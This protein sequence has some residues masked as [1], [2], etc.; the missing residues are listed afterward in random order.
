[1]K[2]EKQRRKSQI[3]KCSEANEASKRIIG[4][5]YDKPVGA[6]S[7][8]MRQKHVAT[9]DQ[10]KL[11]KSKHK[12]KKSGTRFTSEQGKER[13]QVMHSLLY[14]AAATT[15]KNGAETTTSASSKPKILTLNNKESSSRTFAE[16]QTLGTSSCQANS[17]SQ[18]DGLVITPQLP[19]SHRSTTKVNEP[20]G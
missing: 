18:F 9:T 6:K 5:P 11:D 14:Q 16:N 3:S 7:K 17:T 10:L 13:H 20:T 1:M 4:F 15:L 8:Q 12:A 2:A 19:E